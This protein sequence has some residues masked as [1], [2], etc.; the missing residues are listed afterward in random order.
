MHRFYRTVDLSLHSTPKHNASVVQR[1]HHGFGEDTSL[2]IS[3]I[4]DRDLAA[5][6][7]RQ[8]AYIQDLIEHPERAR[9]VISFRW[10]ILTLGSDGPPWESKISEQPTIPRLWDALLKMTN[11]KR[12]DVAHGPM[13]EGADFTASLPDD[14][15][16]FP[17]ATSIHLSGVMEARLVT[18]IL[19]TEKL[20]ILQHLYLDDVKEVAGG[21]GRHLARASLFSDDFTQPSPILGVLSYMTGRCTA[22]KS[23]TIR[24]P[25]QW[26]SAMYIERDLTIDVAVSRRFYTELA[27]FLDSVKGSLERFVL[28]RYRPRSGFCRPDIYFDTTLYPVLLSGPWPRLCTFCMN[29]GK[30]WEESDVLSYIEMFEEIRAAVG[31]DVELLIP[32]TDFCEPWN[33]KAEK[34]NLL[35]RARE[36]ARKNEENL[37]R[38]RAAL[39]Y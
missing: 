21:S 22:L 31:P 19:H 24:K 8:N 35:I 4:D 32:Q 37:R 15:K 3:Q 7:Y 25:W 1:I 27:G 28:D 26:E 10:T 12:V 2:L 38:L 9:F 16:L 14:V 6:R 13:D 17:S 29:C 30:E 18:S 23:L 5:Y 33:E 11:V 36:K 34:V 39:G 20:G